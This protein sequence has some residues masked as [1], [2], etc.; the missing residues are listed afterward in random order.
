MTYLDYRRCADIDAQAF[1]ST[2]P[3]PWL[4]A[5]RLVTDEAYRHLREHLPDAA[6]FAPSFGRRRRYGQASHDRYMLEYRADLVLAEPWRE[7]IGELQGPDYRGF[8]ARLIG[9]E[10]FGLRFH[11]HY[12]PRGCSVSPHCEAPWKFGR[13]VFYF[14]SEEDWD[15]AWGG[16][17]L[18]LDDEGR[19][20]PN[21]A[22]RFEDFPRQYAAPGMG[23]ASL[24]FVRGTHSW[25]GVEPLACPEGVLRKVF[26]VELRKD[27]P[28]NRLQ[29]VFEH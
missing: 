19:F 23:N 9:T 27:R 26:L 10:R 5:E 7:F 6:M 24:L 21:S 25:H 8:I 14:N 2:E 17:T 18:V 11:W 1:R 29:G 16:Q 12:T 13:H 4:V 3:Y 22:P 20:P 28:L 15:P